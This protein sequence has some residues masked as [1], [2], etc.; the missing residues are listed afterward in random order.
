MFNSNISRIVS[1]L[2]SMVLVFSFLVVPAF[3]VESGG[4][5]GGFWDVVYSF[6][7]DSDY[8][9]AILK[10]LGQLSSEDACP[11]S[12]TG[13]HVGAPYH[14][15]KPG[16]RGAYSADCRCDV[17]GFEFSVVLNAD[18]L[19]AAY[20]AHVSDLPANNIDSNGLSRIYITGWTYTCEGLNRILE[21]SPQYFYVKALYS[22]SDRYRITVDFLS[23]TFSVP[24]S[25]TYNIVWPKPTTSG[26]SSFDSNGLY[27]YSGIFSDSETW[28]LACLFGSV[29][30][31]GI[32]KAVSLD[33]S[34][35][36]FFRGALP[37]YPVTAGG[38]VSYVTYPYI[39]G[40]PMGSASVDYS[41]T[42]RP[43]SISGD[44]GIIGDDGKIVKVEG[45]SLSIVNETNNTYY[46]PATGQTSPIAD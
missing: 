14:V 23:G 38:T 3:A 21:S 16:Q 44:Y 36:Y 45:N 41:T 42:T 20:D 29:R 40:V 18:E 1:A 27:L 19:S 5:R 39:D 11:S 30:T 33:S 25:G 37:C 46:N 32:E 43:A 35:T 2:L 15:R 17:C 34:K 8:G 31:D 6:S 24:V 10:G 13:H 12:E 7:D 28:E 4:F 9:K 22:S 26:I